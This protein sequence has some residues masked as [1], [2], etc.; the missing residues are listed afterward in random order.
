[1]GKLTQQM[2]GVALAGLLSVGCGAP[3]ATPTLVPRTATPIPPTNTPK[4]A[5]PTTTFT[6]VPPPAAATATNAGGV[7]TTRADMPTGR[8]EL[9][10]CVVDGKIFA[11]GGAGPVHEALGTVEVYDPATDTWTDKSEM[12]TARQALSTSVVNGKIYAIGGGAAS[13][14][15]YATVETFSTVEEYDPSLDTWTKKSDM[16]TPRLCHHAAVVDGKIYVIGGANASAPQVEHIRTVEVYDPA[17][18][19]WSQKGDMPSSRASGY[20]TVVDGKIYLIGGYEGP[21]RVEEYD[22][23]TDSWKTKS[24]MPS[25]RRSLTTS[26]LDGKIYAIGGYVPDVPGHAGVAT[27]EVYDPAT[28][29]WTSA[30]SMPTARFAPR[31]GVVDGKIYVIGGMGEWVGSAYRTVEEYLP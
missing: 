4:A 20:S 26:A 23:S 17:T 27:V 1:M 24:E 9:S 22:P 7:W 3:V 11:I 2:I 19:T 29:T 8:W 31:S 16:P 5:P 28:D 25:A 13:S 12:P 18:D 30:P 10:T 15:S 6:P 14:V 21:Q